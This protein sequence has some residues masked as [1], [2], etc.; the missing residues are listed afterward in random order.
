[1]KF[2]LVMTQ[3]TKKTINVLEVPSCRLIILL[4]IIKGFIMVLIMIFYG[5]LAKKYGVTL[6]GGTFTSL[7]ISVI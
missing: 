2:T 7:Q 4:T 5:I 3:I 1:M 6:K